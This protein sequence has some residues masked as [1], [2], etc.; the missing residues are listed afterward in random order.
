[1]DEVSQLDLQYVLYIPRDVCMCILANFSWN[2]D[3]A[4]AEWIW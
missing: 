3:T 1:M 2:V 4:Q